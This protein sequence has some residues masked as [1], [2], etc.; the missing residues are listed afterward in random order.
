M[1]KSNDEIWDEWR[2]LVNM[3]PAELERWLETDDSR[4]V[5]DTGG[6]GKSTGHKSGKRIVEIKRAKKEDLT[7]DQRAHMGKVVGY[8]KRHLAQGGPQ[9]DMERSD[10]RIR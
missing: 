3:A 6:E 2:D 10:W 5:G 1:A 8:I 7:D 9:E 4:R